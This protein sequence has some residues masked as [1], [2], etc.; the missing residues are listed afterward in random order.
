MR[1]TAK[2]LPVLIEQ[3][4][5]VSVVRRGRST[6]GTT[7]SELAGSLRQ[8]NYIKKEVYALLKGSDPKGGLPGRC[9]LYLLSDELMAALIRERGKRSQS[10]AAVRGLIES[11]S[12]SKKTV[13]AGVSGGNL[14]SGFVWFICEFRG[15]MEGK[16][17]GAY[18]E[19]LHRFQRSSP[20]TS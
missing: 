9:R 18:L 8:W 10:Q 19:S 5:R 4:D 2:L 11:S 15:E 16:A 12:P 13:L 3:H 20:T 6:T 1:R 14:G 7:M 17:T